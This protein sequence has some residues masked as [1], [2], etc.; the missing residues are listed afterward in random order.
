MTTIPQPTTPQPTSPLIDAAT[1]R[2]RLAAG[3]AIQLLDCS[4]DLA[5]PAAGERGFAERHLPGAIYLHLDRDLSTTKTG[6]NGRHPLPSREAFAAT[7]AAKGVRDDAL[8]VTYDNAAGMYAAR[9]WWMLRW[10]GHAQAQVLDG[11]TAA[12]AATGG[13][14]ESGTKAAAPR[15]AFELR[16]PLES[17]IDYTTLRAELGSPN[18]VVVDARAPDRFRGEN[19][20]LDPIGGHIPGALNRLFRNNLADDGRFKPAEELRSEWT[21]LLTGFTPAQ[22]VMQCGSGVTACHN[23]LAMHTAGLPG[24]KLYPGSWSEWSAQPDTVIETEAPTPK[25]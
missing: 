19:E 9:A 18:R 21:A 13:T 5:D 23:L 15:P 24:A 20:T 7:L 1:L 16:A 22:S 2:Q 8:L 17:T 10:L 14:F 11:G 25:P 3:E 4:F 12:W 6:R